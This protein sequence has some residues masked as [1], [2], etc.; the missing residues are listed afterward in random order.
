MYITCISNFFR[1]RMLHIGFQAVLYFTGEAIEDD[2]DEV[3]AA[4]CKWNCCIEQNTI[5]RFH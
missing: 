4:F 5:G 1:F 2:E 3:I